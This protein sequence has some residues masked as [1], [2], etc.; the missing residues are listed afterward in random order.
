MLDRWGE[1][2]ESDQAE[3]GQE[4]GGAVSVLNGQTPPAR[5][6]SEPLRIFIVKHPRDDRPV[7]MGVDPD[8]RSSRW[9]ER[10]A[11]WEGEDYTGWYTLE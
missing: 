4:L 8:P 5:R 9:G 1:K 7:I 6:L 3:Q 2:L 10:F 11:G